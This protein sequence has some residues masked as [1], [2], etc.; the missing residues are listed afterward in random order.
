MVSYL[1]SLASTEEAPHHRRVRRSRV[2]VALALLAAGSGAC[3]GAPPPTP[4][5][6][7]EAPEILDC[8]RTWAAGPTET[9]VE[10]FPSRAIARQVAAVW[11]QFAHHPVVVER[12]GDTLVVHDDARFKDSFR[13]FVA[14]VRKEAAPADGA[15]RAPFTCRGQRPAPATPTTGGCSSPVWTILLPSTDPE[16]AAR[17]Y[18]AGFATHDGLAG[19]IGGLLVLKDHEPDVRKF[20]ER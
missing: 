1:R 18:C 11:C 6:P 15:D 4:P 17:D 14:E 20:L 8:P 7:V 13:D 2:R 16:R 12:H 3:R 9:V 10:R 19:V 5:A